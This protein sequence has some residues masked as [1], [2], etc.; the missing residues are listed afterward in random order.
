MVFAVGN[1]KTITNEI[2][3]NEIEARLFEKQV[4]EYGFIIMRNE[5]DAWAISERNGKENEGEC[6]G[7]A[8][9][10]RY[11]SLH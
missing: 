7:I 3:A 2:G 10:Q 4:G 1:N 11:I 6:Q 9:E 5:S 8:K